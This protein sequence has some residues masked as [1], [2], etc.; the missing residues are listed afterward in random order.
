VIDPEVPLE[1]PRG[2]DRLARSD[3]KAGFLA[4]YGEGVEVR[5]RDPVRELRAGRRVGT[6]Q[7]TRAG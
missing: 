4:A 7:H 3:K 5:R 2:R 6:A 1:L